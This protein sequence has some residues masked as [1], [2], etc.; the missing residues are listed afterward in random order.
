MEIDSN[1]W[2]AQYLSLLRCAHYTSRQPL[3]RHYR[4]SLIDRTIRAASD[5]L[6]CETTRVHNNTASVIQWC[7]LWT[8]SAQ[9]AY[10]SN[11]QST[12]RK[13]CDLRHSDN[14]R[15]FAV[16]HPHPLADIKRQ[17][18]GGCSFDALVDW[19]DAYGRAVIITQAELQV[20]PQL[21]KD[22]YEKLGITYSRFDPGNASRLR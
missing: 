22:R 10:L 7:L 14:K 3:L 8:H 15:F 11:T 5:I 18:L 20:L 16:E 21:G 13:T 9:R 19:M 12:H 2:R 1:D 4:A 17:V 6:S